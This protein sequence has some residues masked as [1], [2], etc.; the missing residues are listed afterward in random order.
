M[1]IQILNFFKEALQRLKTKSPKFFFVLQMIGI[2]MLLLGK[3][4]WALERWTTL[5]VSQQFL[6]FCHDVSMISAGFVGAIFFTAKAPPVALTEEGEVLNKVEAQKFAFSALSEKKE[7]DKL[8]GQVPIVHVEPT[9][10]DK[11][12]KK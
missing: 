3:L 12:D 2:G 9:E 10:V 7:A 4:P 8:A 11:K 5:I 1:D 6:N